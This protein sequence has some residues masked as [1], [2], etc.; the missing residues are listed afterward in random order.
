MTSRVLVAVRIAAPPPRVFEAF[1]AEIGEWW[2]PDRLFRPSPRPGG[3]LSFEPGMSGVVIVA[4]AF[5]GHDVR[6]DIGG[7]WRSVPVE[8]VERTVTSVAS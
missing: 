3:R 2:R 4:A 1:T 5:V 8:R 7:G 6:D